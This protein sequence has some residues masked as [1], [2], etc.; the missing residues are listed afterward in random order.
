MDRD[1]QMLVKVVPVFWS[2]ILTEYRA[3]SFL[4]CV[5]F[6][7]NQHGL[8]RVVAKPTQPDFCK[9]KKT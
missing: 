2:G 6:G 4:M 8:E 5:S 9:K 3:Y 1:S 7:T